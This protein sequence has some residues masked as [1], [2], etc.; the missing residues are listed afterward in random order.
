V[1]F[2]GKWTVET[3]Q[4]T[5]LCLAAG[6][7]A[8]L[9][10]R[11]SD[12]EYRPTLADAWQT[13][14][15]GLYAD[16]FGQFSAV[17][18]GREAQLGLALT[19]LNR[20]PVTP[21]SLD[22]AQLALAALAAGDDTTGHA[23][24]YFLG[25]MQQMH[26]VHPDARAALV[27]YERLVAT[28]A[29]DPWCRLALVKLAILRLTVLPGPGPVAAQLAAVEP[30]LAHTT[31]VATQH[32]LH[33]VISE[34]RMNHRI[35]DATTLG[36]LQAALATTRVGDVSRPE[37]LIQVARVATLLGQREVAREHYEKYLHDYPHERRAFTVSE[38]LKHLDG[39]FPP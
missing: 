22:E 18:N 4:R 20:S 7:W 6:L 38:A 12:A 29:D 33:I 32:D 8:A 9:P 1:N 17:G 3:L 31:D 28:G 26:P 35:Y 34:V 23:A 21:T 16:A 27:E 2:A 19:Q 24:R 30:L 10:A 39:P 5:L 13:L 36:H 11:A 25:R 15:V 37:M 14:S